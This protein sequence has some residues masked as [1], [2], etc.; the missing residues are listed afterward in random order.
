MNFVLGLLISLISLSSLAY[1][2]D[3]TFTDSFGTETVQSIVN[4]PRQDEVFVPPGFDDLDDA[5]VT[6]LNHSRNSCFI[7]NF[8]LAPDIDQEKKIIRISNMSLVLDSDFCKARHISTPATI[9][10][11]ALLAGTYE[12]QFETASG[13]FK[14]FSELKIGKSKTSEKDDYEYAPLDINELTVKVDRRAQVIE[15]T[16][17]GIFPN[18][19]YEFTEV[20]VLKERADNVIEVLPIVEMKSEVCTQELQPFLKKVNISYD[21]NGPSKKLIH[22]RSADGVAI[23]RVVTVN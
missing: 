15:L 21:G 3:V 4:P 11:G 8:T 10:F 5:E 7:K 9:N 23:N 14:K 20:R 2:G 1:A 12:V 17:P 18:G 13:Q 19:C 16:L 22:I 6:Y